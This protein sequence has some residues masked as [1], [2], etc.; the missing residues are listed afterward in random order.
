MLF[1]GIGALDDEFGR[2]V[3][4]YGIVKLVLYELEEIFGSLG[5][6][7]VVEGRGVDVGHL[8][9]ELTL[10]ETD[11]ADELELTVEVA[12]PEAVEGYVREARAALDRWTEDKRGAAAV[13]GRLA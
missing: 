5:G 4:M 13:A 8:L 3:A 10:A 6:F 1:V 7:V 2:G 12:A 11:F 9:V